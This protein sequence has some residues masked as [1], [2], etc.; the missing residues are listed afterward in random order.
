MVRSLDRAV[1]GVMWITREREA[2]SE[3]RDGRLGH[4]N[5]EL[6]QVCARLLRHASK[7]S[8]SRDTR[9]VS[10]WRRESDAGADT[11]VSVAQDGCAAKSNAASMRG[12]SRAKAHSRMNGGR[13]PKA[14][15]PPT[16]RWVSDGNARCNCLSRMRPRKRRSEGTR[17]DTRKWRAVLRHE[18]E[19][20][21]QRSARQRSP[22]ASPKMMTR[23]SRGRS[24]MSPQR[25]AGWCVA[26]ATEPAA[27]GDSGWRRG[28]EKTHT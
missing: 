22:P 23:T 15:V 8:D 3:V 11:A 27:S 14:R 28:S 9:L 16:W 7:C 18:R 12:H 5:E 10:A 24:S 25:C 21:R 6:L 1:S 17:A 2:R 19:T 4:W 26:S 13:A 20:R